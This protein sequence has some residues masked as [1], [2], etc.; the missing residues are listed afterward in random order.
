[1]KKLIIALALSVSF[2]TPASAKATD[3][4]GDIITARQKAAARVQVRTAPTPTVVVPTDSTMTRAYAV[5]AAQEAMVV[6]RLAMSGT[7]R[8][9]RN[10]TAIR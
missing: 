1:M 9:V 3:I 4:I 10:R 8:A 6:A 7:P 5:A 2:A